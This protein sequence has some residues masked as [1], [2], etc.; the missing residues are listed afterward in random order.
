MEFGRFAHFFVEIKNNPR[1]TPG[2]LSGKALMARLF[3]GLLYILDDIFLILN[4]NGKTDQLVIDYQVY[5]F[6]GSRLLRSA[7]HRI[8]SF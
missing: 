3:K 5:S 4:S 7:L 2:C 6:D 8:I 1:N